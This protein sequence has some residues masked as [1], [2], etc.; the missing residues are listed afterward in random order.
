MEN[1]IN[2][3][4]DD[5]IKIDLQILNLLKDRFNISEQI[6]QIKKEHNLP[7]YDQNREKELLN[8]LKSNKIIKDEYLDS[9]W[10]EIMFISRCI[11]KDLL[12]EKNT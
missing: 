12:Q 7:I 1:K 9:I 10:Y 6:G 11:Q 5:I 2:E 4:R 8:T 3:F